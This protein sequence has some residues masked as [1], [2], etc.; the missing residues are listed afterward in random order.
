M[1]TP[2]DRPEQGEPTPPP[3]DAPPQ[4]PAWDRPSGPEQA[5]AGPGYGPPG[6]G[7]QGYGAP[8]AWGPP[9]AYAAPAGYGPPQ[10]ASKAIIALVL[11]IGSWV[12]FP[13]VPAVVALVLA[14]QAKRDIE[15]SGDRLAGAGMVTAAKIISWTN[16]AV[17][18][19]AG[20]LFLLVLGVFAT[21]VW[22]TV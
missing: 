13:F 12:V 1:S 8:P 6:H 11:S 21:G 9:P 20:L 4:A 10:T 15:A 5:S 19:G 3:W 16:I 14:G 17:T 18:V 2:D 22:A 7:Q